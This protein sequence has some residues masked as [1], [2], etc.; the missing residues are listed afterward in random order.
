MTNYAY[1][2]TEAYQ[3]LGFSPKEIGNWIGV[4]ASDWKDIYL[5]LYAVKIANQ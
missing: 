1:K 3:T 5:H 2:L 4:D